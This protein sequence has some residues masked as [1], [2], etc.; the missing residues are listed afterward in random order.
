MQKLLLKN[1]QLML[2]HQQTMPL[3]NLRQ[4]MLPQAAQMTLDV[5]KEYNYETERV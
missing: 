3:M 5:K 2:K 4:Q 1:Q